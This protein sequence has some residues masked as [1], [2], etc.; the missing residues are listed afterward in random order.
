QAAQ[1]GE[2]LI[3]DATLALVR[4]AVEAE[5][6]V[7]LEL[8]GKADAVKARRLVSVHAAPQRSHAATFVGRADEL[9]ALERAWQRVYRGRRCELV[10]VVGEAG[11]GKSRLTAEALGG[12]DGRVLSGRC[13]PYGEGITYW[14]VVEVVKQLNAIPSDAAA[15]AAI[16]SLLGETDAATSAEE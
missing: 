5:A 3:G 10:T 1:P 13:L 15:A 9:G 8:K 14:P 11:V 16:L 2:I 6:V 7:P 12:I 4:E